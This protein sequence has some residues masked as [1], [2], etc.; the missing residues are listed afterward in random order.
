MSGTGTPI[1]L[2]VYDLSN[3]MAK[4]FGRALTGTD[5]EGIWHTSLV[6]FGMEV[7]YG[8]GISIISPPG[9]THHGTPL[10][11]LSMGTTE[12]DRQTFLEYIESMKDIY[13]AEA[14]HLLDFN[15]N[16][17]T[18]DVLGFLNGGTIPD[19]IRNLPRDILA[20]PFGQQMRPMIDQLFS[21]RSGPP[22]QTAVESLM[23]Q[24]PAS[25]TPSNSSL[26][27]NLQISTSPSSLRSILQ[28]SDAAA[29][30]YTS[31]SCP[32]C[33]AVRPAFEE[34][35]RTHPKIAFVLC[36]IGVAGGQEIAADSTGEFGGPVKAT[37]TFRFYLK[38]AVV[39]E[40][41]GGDAVEL[42][43]QVGM[44]VLQAFPPHPHENL[45]LP[46]LRKLCKALGPVTYPTVPALP[47]LST[48]L[49]SFFTDCTSPSLA[50]STPTTLTKRVIAYL[51]TLPTPPAAPTTPLS[52]GL[53]DAWKSATLNALAVLPPASWFPVLDLWRIGLARDGAR[54]A[55]AFAGI[56]PSLLSTVANPALL[57]SPDMIKPLLLTTLRLVSNALPIDTLVIALLSP[58]GAVQDT[59]RL[60][61]RALLDA[62]KS[63]RSVGAGLAWS[64]V[65]RVWQHR[66][67][68]DGEIVGGEEWEVEIA[69]AILEA[70]GREDES[71]EV[72]MKLSHSLQVVVTVAHKKSSLL[73]VHRLAA[74]LG[75]LALE[76]PNTTA[77][78]EIMGALDGPSVV[79]SKVPMCADNKEVEALLKEVKV[80][81]S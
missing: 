21:G 81:L 23:P 68:E 78:V 72:G 8:Q 5:I 37:P 24:L 13:R 45:P 76:S 12:V 69:C 18:N 19:D 43:T 7:F 38:G 77:L 17:F 73:A 31:A 27:S 79:E 30:M 52:P 49:S 3:G 63:V 33:V 40:C 59:T 32:P 6:L 39:G 9:T 60:V 51:A 62:D 70:L 56:L 61:V 36:E 65:G 50:E 14:Y 44:L 42:K 16:S 55:P 26:S 48:K 4:S 64:I 54:L 20:T 67:K 71:V 75:L 15:C 66:K 22:A 53:V 1:E 10:K 41:K 58:A 28:S 80:L 74:S 25:S 47:S 2:Y 57:D 34:L 35:A 29:V 46:A 11:R